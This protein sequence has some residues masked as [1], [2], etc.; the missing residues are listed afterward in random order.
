MGL[1]CLQLCRTC[2]SRA[3]FYSARRC[4][5][6]T[7]LLP[8]HIK[9]IPSQN[10][11]FSSHL[12][13]L[14]SQ[15][16]QRVV[17]WFPARATQTSGSELIFCTVPWKD[18][19]PEHSTSS[20]GSAISSVLPQAHILWK[21]LKDIGAVLASAEAAGNVPTMSPGWAAPW[22]LLYLQPHC[23]TI[24]EVQF[25]CNPTA[26]PGWLSRSCLQD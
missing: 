24:H 3:E 13:A 12:E 1:P 19:E 20:H 4:Y 8:H 25:I 5:F 6:L 9:S 14:K 10:L 2:S 15:L 11:F 17:N 16:L 7:S 26:F 21:E 22:S 18:Q 23:I